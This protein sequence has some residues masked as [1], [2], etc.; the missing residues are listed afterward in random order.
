MT[1]EESREARLHAA[2][3]HPASETNGETV[4]LVTEEESRRA[5]LHAALAVPA[6]ET[7]GGTVPVA[8]KEDPR[9]ELPVLNS[10]IYANL[11]EADTT[12]PVMEQVRL[13]DEALVTSNVEEH[14]TADAANAVILGSD[15]SSC[16]TLEKIIKYQLYW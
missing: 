4:P 6:S 13:Y 15:D 12:F 9:G 14:V 8:T 10:N 11:G 16:D 1:K 7:N 3:A 5:M 2:P